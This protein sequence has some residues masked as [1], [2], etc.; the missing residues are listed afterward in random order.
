MQKGTGVTRPNIAKVWCVY[1]TTKK[2][3][4][5]LA[6]GENHTVR[7]F[8]ELTFRE[9]GIEIEWKGSE[10]NEK[11]HIKSVNWT[12]LIINRI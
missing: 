5:V 2:P 6:T 11:G 10:E 12:K 4:F 7:E 3:K 9:L 8:T 1:S